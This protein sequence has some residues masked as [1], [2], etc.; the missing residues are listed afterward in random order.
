MN[1]L[2]VRNRIDDNLLCNEE[3]LKSLG[4]ILRNRN[5]ENFQEY[6]SIIIKKIL[7]V[8]KDHSILSEESRPRKG[9]SPF[10]WVIDPLDGT[11]NFVHSFPFFCVS[12]GLEKEGKVLLGVVYDPIHDHLFHAQTGQGAFFNGALLHIARREEMIGN[13]VAFDWAQGR[14]YQEKL[15][16]ILNTVEQGVSVR[17]LGSTALGM[18]YVAAGWLDVFFHICVL[19]WDAA[20]AAVIV[21]EAGGQVVDFGGQPWVLSSPQLLVA[22]KEVI[23]KWI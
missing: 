4:G 5:K 13:L 20:A 21:R 22:S 11:T 23:S 6:L 17:A 1:I 14:E 10:K 15:L 3:A 8:F 19:P 12:I 2:N 7:S 16:H 18:C 9:G